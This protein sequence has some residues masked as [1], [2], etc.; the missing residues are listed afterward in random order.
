ML[1]FYN[2][3]NKRILN[4]IIFLT[5]ML[6]GNYAYSQPIDT[7]DKNSLEE[8][9]ALNQSAQELLDKA[10]ELFSEMAT[11]KKDVKKNSKKTERLNDKALDYTEQ[12]LEKQKEA[13]II[14][15]KVYNKYI[16]QGNNIS[17]KE[18]STKVKASLLVEQAEKFFYQAEMLRIDAYAL[19]KDQKEEK[20]DILKKAQ[21]NERLGLEKQYEAYRIFYNIAKDDNLSTLVSKPG[22]TNVVINETLLNE[23]LNYLAKTNQTTTLEKIRGVAFSDSVSSADLRKE[24][25]NYL[26]SAYEPLAQHEINDSTFIDAKED[27]FML[28]END[29]TLIE[30]SEPLKEK[31]STQTKKEITGK[32]EVYKI[33]IAADKKPISQGALQKIYS[34]DKKV[35]ISEK[36]GWFKYSIGNFNS[37]DEAEAFKDQLGNENAFVVTINDAE[38]SKIDVSHV[39]EDDKKIGDKPDTAYT[40]KVQIAASKTKLND[41]KLKSIYNGNKKINQYTEDG[42]YKYSIGKF[43]NYNEAKKLIQQSGVKDAFIV[44][45]YNGEKVPLYLAKRGIKP[46]QEKVKSSNKIIF[47]VQIAADTEP[48]SSS[49]L[50]KIY[51]GYHPIESYTEDG[52][53][54]Y[55]I[56]EFNTFNEANKLRE[57]SKVKGAFIVA[58]KNGKKIN[59][60][61]AKKI[62]RDCYTPQIINDWK[63]SNDQVVFR[64]QIA[65]SRKELTPFQLKQRYCG[66]KYVYLSLEE[67]WHKYAVGNFSNYNKAS[68]M[69]KTINVS[70]AFIVAYQYGEKLDIKQ[71]INKVK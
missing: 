21:E 25:D 69:K 55:L 20:I 1:Q 47:K 58:F 44:S 2:G 15:Y 11:L 59:V 18:S 50:H 39:N 29:D 36:D 63:S 5:I 57:G 6:V 38:D 24:W 67:P 48:L 46:R 32:K 34:S 35:E 3:L 31:S 64:V 30:L 7:I 4:P 40:F 17:N 9:K 41:H 66:E 13:N 68:Q 70:G 16:N 8:A 22:D 42:W 37:F 60:L 43:F 33:Q 54:K 23:Y 19:P 12:A 52:W 45:S 28:S 53:Y 71:A 26:Y 65:A 51:S 61:D 27:E 10:N 62:V 49:K 56:G 14:T